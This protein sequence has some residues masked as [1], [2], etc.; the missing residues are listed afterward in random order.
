MAQPSEMRDVWNSGGTAVGAWLFLRE[1][2]IAEAASLAGYDYVCI[3]MQHGLAGFDALPGMIQAIAVGPA[4]PLVRVS[5]NE[6]WILGRALDAGAMGVIV[7]M[8]NTPEEAA[9][10]VAACRYA[11][12]GERSIGPIGASTRYPGYVRTANEKVLCIVM[13]ETAQAVERIDEI[14]AVPGIDAAYV[15]PA[16]LG[17]TLGLPPGVDHADARFQAALGAVVGACERHGVVPG[18]HANAGLAG[19]RHS[20]G[21]RFVTVSY[22]LAPVMASLGADLKAS[23]AATNGGD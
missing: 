19:A 9:R 6:P 12:M 5:A 3:D 18:V 8:V 16:D 21:F 14:L 22:D 10:A 13:I 23:R 7:P 1:P 15:G 4:A 2:L 11:P 20:A 17:L